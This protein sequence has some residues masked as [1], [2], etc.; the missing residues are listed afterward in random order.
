ME[1]LGD[2][3]GGPFFSTAYDVS[4]DGSVVVGFSSNGNGPEAFRW[5]S[6]T[7]MVGLGDLPGGGFD[8][9]AYGTSS[10]GSV[11][12]GFGTSGNGR[13]AFVWDAANGMRSVQDVLSSQGIDM[14]GWQLTSATAVSADGNIIVGFGTNPSGAAEAWL[15]N[16]AP[17]S[18]VPEPTSLATWALA[19]IGTIWLA[20]RR[21]RNV[22]VAAS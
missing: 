22:R 7:G 5:T 8:S 18:A 11:I 17:Q 10:D 1:G 20:R 12:V 3:S 14:T 2:L 13:E 9:M 21:K 15:A 16:L 4:S 19:G 6:A